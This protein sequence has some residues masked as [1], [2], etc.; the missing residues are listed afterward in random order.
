MV[1]QLKARQK[2][3]LILASSFFISSFC[4]TPW[5]ESR[6]TGQDEDSSS[7]S[8]YLMAH[9]TDDDLM[10]T[11]M[12]ED[13]R[14]SVDQSAALRLTDVNNNHSLHNAPS[15][16]SGN[17]SFRSLVTDLSTTSATFHDPNVSTPDSSPCIEADHSNV[18]NGKATRKGKKRCSNGTKS[19]NTLKSSS[20]SNTALNS[21]P[22]ATAFK[23][24]ISRFLLD[25][26]KPISSFLIGNA[27]SSQ[28][29]TSV[30]GVSLASSLSPIVSGSPQLNSLNVTS[31]N[32]TDSIGPQLLADLPVTFLQ[33]AIDSYKSALMPTQGKPSPQ[34]DT[35]MKTCTM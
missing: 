31:D 32:G 27:V 21:N 3:S 5:F 28:S 14:Q 30:A 20:N 19:E 23:G 17:A 12:T 10:Q 4:S 6:F 1:A 9:Q 24:S 8:G 15:A 2:Q 13:E 33:N 11:M 22:P 18:V 25:S 29:T 35:V 34:S 7:S 16:A 26:N